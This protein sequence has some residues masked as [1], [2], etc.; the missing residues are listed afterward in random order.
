MYL[1]GHELGVRFGGPRV[2][3]NASL[4][5]NT[6]KLHL[7]MLHH[8]I[9]DTVL[10]VTHRHITMTSAMTVILHGENRERILIVCEGWGHRGISHSQIPIYTTCII[11]YSTHIS[12][13]SRKFLKGGQSKISRDRVGASIRL[14]RYI[15]KCQGGASRFQGGAKAPSRPPLKETLHMIMHVPSLANYTCI[16]KTIGTYFNVEREN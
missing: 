1:E 7:S 12:V 10:Q 8:T 3:L 15:W 16:C 4:S 11:K 14:V 13:S 9:V 6:E 5:T 2:D